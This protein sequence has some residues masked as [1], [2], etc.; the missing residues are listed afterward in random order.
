M[1]TVDAVWAAGGALVA[2]AAAGFAFYAWQMRARQAMLHA[3]E[4]KLAQG[5]R[6]GLEARVLEYQQREAGWQRQHEVLQEQLRA[7]SGDLARVQAQSTQWDALQVRHREA[8][9][10]L[11]ALQQELAASRASQADL[12]ARLEAAQAQSEE[13][14][15]LLEQA[16]AQMRA[17]F[18]VLAQQ[19]LEEKSRQFLESNQTQVGG[20]LDPLRA[21]LDDFRKLVSETYDK[22]LRERVGLKHELESL[23]GLNQKLGDEAQ[24]LTRALKGQPQVQGAWGEMVLQR[25]LEDSGLEPGRGYELQHTAAGAQGTRQR[26]DVI[27][28]LPGRR[29]VVIDSKVSL[30]AYERYCGAQTE[31]ERRA[32]LGAHVASLREHVRQLAERNYAALEGLN[33]AELVLMFVPIESAFVEAMRAD[34]KLYREAM[35]KNVAIVTCSTLMVTLRMAE[36]L[37][38]MEHRNQ[39]AQQIAQRAGL[40]YDKFVGFAEDLDRLGTLIKRSQEGFEAARN[41]LTQGNG[42]LVWQAE[43]LKKL[44][45]RTHKALSPGLLG[46]A[47]AQETSAPGETAP[48]RVREEGSA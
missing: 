16:A 13:R 48:Q 30:V 32:Q 1:F 7:M 39:H 34:D 4:L 9:S 24:A 12:R 41:K 42:N 21:Q 5:E 44:G 45:A 31:P 47:V 8:Q 38:R 3:L 18:Q 37:W 25:L 6:Q 10:Q 17:E 14:R 27:V 29:D 40:L 36:S 35:N 20:L 22:E 43:E 11:D 23:R 46:T 26:P 33:S 2:L 15:Q 19:A 28:R